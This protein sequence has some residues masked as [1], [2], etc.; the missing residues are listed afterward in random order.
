ML[1]KYFTMV[2]ILSFLGGCTAYHYVSSP[3]YVPL[4]D[5]KGSV[6]ANISTNGLELG[7]ALTDN[8]NVFANGSVAGA[9][10]LLKD[11]GKEN[12]GHKSGLF[13]QY[14]IDAGAGIYKKG[15]LFN[16]ELLA[17]A[18]GGKISYK[19]EIDEWPENYLSLMD[20]KKVHVYCQPDVGYKLKDIL[21]VG[22]FSKIIYER[23]YD[24]QSE[25]HIGSYSGIDPDDRYFQGRAIADISFIEPGI[26]LR[27][28][29]KHLKFYT[30]CSVPLQL[31]ND[32]ILYRRINVLAGV[33]FEFQKFSPK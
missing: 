25:T 5:K 14:T 21:V 26:L 30:E 29:T 31:V 2:T 6:I 3:Q 4:H 13:R 9:P 11:G 32:D 1:I 22:V 20:A 19:N 18:G 33:S 10:Q 27:V 8:F 12:S 17:G 16:Y 7:Y 15:K 28:G 24:I 23:F